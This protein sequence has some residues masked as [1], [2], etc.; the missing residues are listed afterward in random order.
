M[1]EQLNHKDF[2]TQKTPLPEPLTINDL[3]KVLA[4]GI[5]Q[6][7]QVAVPAD[8]ADG[9]LPDGFNLAESYQDTFRGHA[10]AGHELD[11]DIYD[12][13]GGVSE[14]PEAMHIFCIKCKMYWI[15]DQ[16]YIGQTVTFFRFSM[17]D[18]CGRTRDL[19]HQNHCICKKV[20]DG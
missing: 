3:R 17:C 8:Y 12:V 1:S 10:D 5:A 11:W 16:A 6:S 2:T 13:D 7:K 4:K 18:D 15:V 20:K 9:S 19:P 14:Y